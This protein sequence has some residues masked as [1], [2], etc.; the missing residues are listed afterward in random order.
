MRRLTVVMAV[1]AAAGTIGGAGSGAAAGAACSRATA[2]QLATRFAPGGREASHEVAQVLCGA[3]A[4]P[5]SQAIAVTFHY[6]GCIPLSHWA[7]FVRQAG[8]WQLVLARDEVGAR[9]GRAGSGIRVSWDV[10]RAG[11]P[12]CLPSGG[13]RTRVWRWDGQRFAGG[14]TVETRPPTGAG[15][16]GGS[17]VRFSS[18]SGNLLCSMSDD[19]RAVE[20]DCQSFRAPQ[21]VRL[22]ADGGL[23]VCHGAGCPGNPGEGD[24]FPRLA[25]GRHLT[26][27]RFRCD[28]L[29]SGV[30]C[31]VVGS[32]KGFVIDS[33]AITRIG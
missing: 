30:R 21:S 11:D 17:H 4:G 24:V 18:P 9:L 7:V 26:V 2:Q 29:T 33:R 1:A 25:Y 12:H 6:P 13:E 23:S 31:V 22:F 32:G 10:F 19:A 28:S 5:G 14:P 27:G 8:G 20:A 15:P 16:G 3:F